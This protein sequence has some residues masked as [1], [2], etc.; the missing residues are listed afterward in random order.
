MAIGL[1]AVQVASVVAAA[2]SPNSATA[3]LNHIGLPKRYR[4][5]IPAI[6]LTTASGLL[7]DSRWPR[8]GTASS[9]SLVAFY[10]AAVRFH[11]LAGDPPVVVLPAAGLGTA[12]GLRLLTALSLNSN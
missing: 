7:F 11:R 3:R 10:A 9:A 5:L 12:A 8:L 4:P 6:L 2:A 1:A